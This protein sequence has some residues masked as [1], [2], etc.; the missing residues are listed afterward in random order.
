[1]NNIILPE[2]YNCNLSCGNCGHS[3]QLRIPMGIKKLK[4]AESQVCPNCGCMMA[5][6]GEE[7]VPDRAI[8][9]YLPFGFGGLRWPR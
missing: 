2:S 1:M 7:Y 9:F 8:P 6:Q 5:G 3:T 4:Y